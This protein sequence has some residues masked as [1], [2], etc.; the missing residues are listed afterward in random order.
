MGNKISVL[1]VDP[2]SRRTGLTVLLLED[3]MA[4]WVDAQTLEPD[5]IRPDLFSQYRLNHDV[6][7]VFIEKP[8]GRNGPAVKHIPPTALIAGEVGGMCRTLGL[9]VAYLLAREWRKPLCGRGSAKDS[10]IEIALSAHIDLPKRTNAHVRDAAGV[11]LIGG[12][13][14]LW[15]RPF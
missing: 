11:A 4:T 2:G 7:A 10:E 15:G 1:G 13:E 12:R 8:E 6:S 3:N 14:L 5:Q 9:P